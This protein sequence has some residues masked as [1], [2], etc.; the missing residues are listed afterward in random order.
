MFCKT[1]VI[2]I[3]VFVMVLVSCNGSK[4]E[5]E[6]S[7][8]KDESTSSLE[9]RIEEL[10]KKSAE[11]QKILDSRYGEEYEKALKECKELTKNPNADPDE[12]A[13]VEKKIGEIE[14]KMGMM[15]F[16]GVECKYKEESS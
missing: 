16:M 13:A 9:Q 2:L 6:I 7:S 4:K 8:A 15:H 3:T 11:L 10:Q 5:N 1:K 14:A 12:V